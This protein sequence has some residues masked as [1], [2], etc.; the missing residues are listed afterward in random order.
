MMT[1]VKKRGLCVSL[2]LALLLTLTACATAAGGS[3]SAGASPSTAPDPAASAPHSSAASAPLSLSGSASH[4][5]K[6]VEDTADFMA[7]N[8]QYTQDDY[9]LLE[10]LHTKDWEKQSLAAFNAGFHIKDED[11]FHKVE[12]ALERLFTTLPKK[13]PLY[14]FLNTTVSYSW[15]ACRRQHYYQSCDRNRGPSYSGQAEY[16]RFED[17][18]G[19]KVPVAH[20]SCDFW[21]DYTIPDEAALTVEARDAFFRGLDEGMQTFLSAQKEEALKSIKTMRHMLGLELQRLTGVLGSDQVYATACGV[22]YI[23]ERVYD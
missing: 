3:G 9:A 10:S 2:L 19:D 17:V 18:F 4:E 13:D 14:T 7:T 16:L 1:T 20:G 21:Y 12:S 11:G 5:A 23:W 6:L 22:D 8:M 15:D